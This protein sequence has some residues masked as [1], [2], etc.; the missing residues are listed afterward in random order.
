MIAMQQVSAG[1]ASVLAVSALRP[2]RAAVR[3]AIL[4]LVAS[5]VVL[6]AAATARADG[7]YVPAV[8]YP[9]PP[10]IPTQRAMILFRGGVETL[11]V[12]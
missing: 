6:A 9:A 7:G 8:E 1:P 5:V 11:V 3:V 12:E 2:T 4:S 10:G